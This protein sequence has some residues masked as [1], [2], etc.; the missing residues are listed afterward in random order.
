MKDNCNNYVTQTVQVAATSPAVNYN[1]TGTSYTCST[2]T[3][4]FN[5]T[6]SSSG[7]TVT[8]TNSGHK[9]E[10]WESTSTD[11]PGLPTGTPTQT[12]ILGPGVSASIT[13]N[14]QTKSYYYRVTSPCGESTTGCRNLP[15]FNLT[16]SPQVMVGCGTTANNMIGFATNGQ[17]NYSATITAYSGANGT[18]TVVSGPSVFSNQS[19]TYFQMPAAASYSYTFRDGCG[20]TV[21]GTVNTPT[22]APSVRSVSYA[23]NCTNVIGTSQVTVYFAGIIPDLYSMTTA[24]ATLVNRTTGAVINA[25]DFSRRSQLAIFYNVPVGSYNLV[26]HATNSSCPT[27]I[28]V[29]VAPTNL[30]TYS[31]GTSLTQNCGG[32]GTIQATLTTNGTGPVKYELR[33]SAGGVI[34]TNTSGTFANIPAGQYIVAGIMTNSCNSVTHTETKAVSIVPAGVGPQIVR[35]LGVICEPSNITGIA[36]FSISGASPFN[37]YLYRT[38]EAEPVTPTASNLGTSYTATGLSPNTT[39][40]VRLVDACGNSTSTQV[41]ISPLGNISKLTTMQ[42]CVGSNYTLA[43]D[44]L[45]GATYS[46]SYNGGPEIGSSSALNFQPY[47][48]A[49]DGTYTVTVKIGDCITRTVTYNISSSLCGAALYVNFGSIYAA[50]RQGNL[51]VSWTAL[52][53]LTMRVIL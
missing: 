40:N 53:K 36:A 8:T 15:P 35:K 9:I 32:T 26:L 30:L 52:R 46:W 12:K 19:S 25:T 39:Y 43:V 29:N 22:A 47:A 10:I 28:P 48:A 17:A 5:F 34:S 27:T 24:S 23:L 31:L 14:A 20:N 4:S 38:G 6:N 45:P 3:Q 2:I 41:T 1:V 42:P 7:Q 16:A 51:F 50:F 44:D 18:G 33:N 21:T 49:N 37:I 13:V 11:C